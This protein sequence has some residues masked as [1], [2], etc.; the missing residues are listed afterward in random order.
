MAFGGSPIIEERK[1]REIA[2][3]A[4]L[5]NVL[6]PVLGNFSKKGFNP[7]TLVFQ[8]LRIC[9]NQELEVLKKFLPKAISNLSPGGRLAVIS[10]HRLEDRLV[11]SSTR[12]AASEFKMGHGRI[13]R[14]LPK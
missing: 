12:Q 13:R 9:V 7:V 4:D 11:K 10:F 14:P 1:Q 8:A 2:T 6:K 3:T 5:V